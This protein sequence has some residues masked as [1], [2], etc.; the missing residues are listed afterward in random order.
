VPV[1]SRHIITSDRG[2]K[3]AW[4]NNKG[5]ALLVRP[6][7]VRLPGYDTGFLGG[8]SGVTQKAVFFVGSLKYHPDGVAIRGLIKKCGKGVIELYD[9]PLYD[10]G[11]ILFFPDYRLR[12][13]LSIEGRPF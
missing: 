1:D 2:I 8:A 11:S 4:E 5:K 9:G 10:V 13:S 6:G 3:S 7:H 12:P